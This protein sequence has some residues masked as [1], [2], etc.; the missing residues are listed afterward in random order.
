M[1][2]GTYESLADSNILAETSVAFKAKPGF[3]TAE[4]ELLFP[5]VT[6]GM[7]RTQIQDLLGNPQFD[8]PLAS[9]TNR[10]NY[11]IYYS[12]LLIVTF[13]NDHVVKTEAVGF[14]G[15]SNGQQGGPG[16]PPQGVG[17]PDP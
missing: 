10:W 1:V 12:T 9:S 8:G 15:K 13:D 14:H 4:A 6:N 2:I 3:R 5:F 16:Y 7:L 11:S 17:S